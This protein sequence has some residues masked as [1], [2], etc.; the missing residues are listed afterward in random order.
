MARRQGRTCGEGH[1]NDAVCCHIT[2]IVGRLWLSLT[3]TRFTL[4][5]VSRTCFCP[6]DGRTA[7][8]YAV[9]PGHENIVRLL[10]DAG[11]NANVKDRVG[12][13]PLPLVFP[14]R[15]RS[16]LSVALPSTVLF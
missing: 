14:L 3:V 16:P 6:Q 15:C 9:Q 2:H 5:C 4:P 7:L 12:V 10:L 1:G 13:F 8:I 11:A